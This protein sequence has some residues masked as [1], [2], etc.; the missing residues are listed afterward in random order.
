MVTGPRN[1]APSVLIVEDEDRLRKLVSVTLK[2]AGYDTIEAR[3]G[4]EALHHLGEMLPDLIL[5]DV[6]MPEV[7]GFELLRR[8][9][10]NPGTRAIPVILLTARAGMD[11]VVGGLQLGADDYLR[12]PFEMPELLARV[13]AKIERPSVPAEM[14]PQDRQTG[15]LTEALFLDELRRELARASRSGAPVSVGCIELQE[16]PTVLERLGIRGERSVARQVS[17]A[18]QRCL[19][20]LGLAGRNAASEFLVLLPEMSVADATQTLN[21]VSAAIA[22]TGF[23]VGTERLRITPAAGIAAADREAGAETLVH[24]A[25]VARKHASLHLDLQSTSWTPE[26][27]AASAAAEAKRAEAVK[28]RWATWME[29]L[30]VPLQIVMTLAVGLVVPFLI[31]WT[32][33]RAGHDITHVMYLIV[34]LSLVATAAFIWLEGFL[35]LRRVD[36]P[37]EP[38]QPYPRASAIIAAYLPNEAATIVETVKAFLEIDYP[39]GLQI[40]VAYNTPKSLPVEAELTKIAAANPSVVPLRVTHSTSK[41]QNVNSAL[42]V[43]TGEFIGVFDADHH[44]Q[45]DSFHRAWRWLSTGY[46]VVQG[47]CVIRNGDASWVAKMTAVEFEAIYAVAH[48]GRARMHGFGLFGGS[49]GYWRTDVLRE[50]RFHGSMLTEDIDSS[51]RVIESGRRIQSDP[52]LLS[53]ELA[54]AQLKALWNQRLR[55]AQGWFQVSMMHVPIALRSR[56]L[57]WRQKLGIIHLLAWREI[58]PWVSLQMFPIIAFWAA[59]RGFERIDWLV[60]VFVMTTIFTLGTGP[61]QSF[62]IK[63]CAVQDIRDRKGWVSWYAMIAFV[64]YTEFKNLIARVAQVKEFMKERAWKVTPRATPEVKRA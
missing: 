21:V 53:T 48:P 50:I 46:D 8:V 44:P 9:R 30:R 23:S 58:F 64:F 4:V 16:L 31:Y 42:A 61:G 52:W 25:Q 43:A 24:R 22:R 41:A 49:N 60:P 3:N 55:W 59:T 2:R 34:T 63:R 26:L 62:F 1:A 45:H 27:E 6:M 38:A 39:E 28:R 13:R 14:L 5:S 10:E 12:K 36:P 37:E 57:N 29:R 18:I 19:P 17:E 54:P 7:D 11:D 35:A 33:W 20:P 32:L 51:L 56:K 47:H 15:L 40:I